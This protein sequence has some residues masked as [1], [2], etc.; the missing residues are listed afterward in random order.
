MLPRT[1]HRSAICGAGVFCSTAKRVSG[2]PLKVLPFGG[3]YSINDAMA[4]GRFL[5]MIAGKV[6]LFSESAMIRAPY[7]LVVVRPEGV[8]QHAF[9]PTAV[10]DLQEEAMI[11]NT[12]HHSLV[13]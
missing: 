2:R 4:T 3:G 11:R 6:L 13:I 8:L 12:N 9:W 10:H 1:T 5:W 7:S